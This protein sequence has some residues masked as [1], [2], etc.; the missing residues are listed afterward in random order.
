LTLGKPDITGDNNS[1]DTF[2]GMADIAI[3]KNGDVFIADGE[4]PN[5]R[6]AKFSKG[7]ALIKWWGGKGTGPGRFNGPHSIAVDS[8]GRW[9][10]RFAEG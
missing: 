4:G 9:T 10:L 1:H 2:N 8:K 6:V 7:G 5:T 3:A